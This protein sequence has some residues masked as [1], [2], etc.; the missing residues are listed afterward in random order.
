MP[1]QEAVAWRGVGLKYILCSV[2]LLQIKKTKQNRTIKRKKTK[3]TGL[4]SSSE[5]EEGSLSPPTQ[6]PPRHSGGC[7]DYIIPSMQTTGCTHPLPGEGE[8]GVMMS[9]F[10]GKQYSKN[11]LALAAW[12]GRE[13]GEVW[14]AAVRR[15]HWRE[16][17]R[18]A[19]HP[20]GE[21]GGRQWGEEVPSNP[22][23]GTHRE[24]PQGAPAWQRAGGLLAPTGLW[25][26]SCP[27]R[28]EARAHL[29]PCST[30]NKPETCYSKFLPKHSQPQTG[31]STL[32]LPRAAGPAASAASSL[33]NYPVFYQI[34]P[35]CG[36]PRYSSR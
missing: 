8:T 36:A 13:R 28:E 27:P 6:P 4:K 34:H 9:M 1:R 24:A 31:L 12:L 35:V 29:S 25:E 3:Q 22:W 30:E 17:T 21:T 7:Q 32:R 18:G 14:L 16:E 10:R 15:K 26:R 33:E 19:E 23:K 2:S 11:L 20:R 5:R